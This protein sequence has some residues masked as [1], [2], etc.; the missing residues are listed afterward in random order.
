MRLIYEHGSKVINS[1]FKA[2]KDTV[3][4]APKGGQQEQKQQQEKEG[5]GGF[6]KFSFNNLIATPMTKEE[7]LKILNL[8][9]SD[10][11]PEKILE[12]FEK[13]FESNDPMKGGS[14][15]LQNKIYYAKEMLMEKYPKEL[16]KSKHN[17]DWS[18]KPKADN[19][20]EDKKE[21]NKSAEEDPVEKMKNKNI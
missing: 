17:P 4:N 18:G 8:K 19:K 9:E 6:G 16:N 2:Y 5:Q 11:T 20:E 12:Q 10:S 7:A 1:V 14:F 3:K 15:Y 21:E 13:Y